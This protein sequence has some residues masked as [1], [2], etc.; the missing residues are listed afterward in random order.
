MFQSLVHNGNYYTL[1]IF[2]QNTILKFT[3]KYVLITFQQK[4]RVPDNSNNFYSIL[5]TN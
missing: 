4:L 1:Q 2:N 3:L 5:H